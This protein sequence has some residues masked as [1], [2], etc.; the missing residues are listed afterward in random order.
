MMY[1]NGATQ[2]ISIHAPRTESDCIRR[3]KYRKR[4]ISIH[5]PR[6]GSDF[7][8]LVYDAS[9][10]QFQSTLPARGATLVSRIASSAFSRFQST[11]PARGATHHHHRH[12]GGRA[13]S[14]HAPRTGSDA[15]GKLRRKST[16]RFQST[17]PARGATP[18]R[19]MALPVPIFQSTLPARGATATRIPVDTHSIISI[20]A[21]RTGSDAPLCDGVAVG[22]ISIHAPRTGSDAISL[23]CGNSVAE[24]QSTLPARGATGDLGGWIEAE[25][26]Q[27]TLP[28]RGA[29]ISRAVFAPTPWNFNPRS[30]HG[31]RRRRIMPGGGAIFISIHAPR[32]GSDPSASAFPAGM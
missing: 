21:P 5:A 2:A 20:H 22:G 3:T 23:Y 13:I 11:L 18:M 14:I 19:V 8:A 6:T 16:H 32:T 15:C 26:F 17:L 31:E 25:R 9:V 27:S 30:P 29:T 12:F 1:A 24:F 7:R 10:I 4:G 28:A